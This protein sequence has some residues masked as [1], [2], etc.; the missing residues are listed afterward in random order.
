MEAIKVIGF[1]WSAIISVFL[2]IAL[3][4]PIETDKEGNDAEAIIM[5]RI[6]LVAGL[7]GGICSCVAQTEVFDE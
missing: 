5:L 7:A 4:S 1:M 2:F 3:V 6:V